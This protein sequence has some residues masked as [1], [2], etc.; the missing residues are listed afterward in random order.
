[1]IPSMVLWVQWEAPANLF[2]L[3]PN[4]GKGG[5]YRICCSNVTPVHGREIVECQQHIWI[6]AAWNPH[7]N[8]VNTCL[9]FPLRKISVLH[10]SPLLAPSSELHILAK[11]TLNFSL[12]SLIK[13]LPCPFTQNL[14]ESAT[15][16]C[17]FLSS[18]TVFSLVAGVSFHFLG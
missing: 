1:M 6:T 2:C 15:N 8:I 3:Q 18:I 11:N 7:C 13:K 10:D 9:D 4:S 12:Q 14:R 16:D 17:G 5:F